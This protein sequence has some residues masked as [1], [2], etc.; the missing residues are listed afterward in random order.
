[1]VGRRR[2]VA[3]TARRVYYWRPKWWPG[4]QF[5]IM[6][7]QI[8]WTMRRGRAI[9][10]E[11]REFALYDAFLAAHE[12]YRPTPYPGRISLWRAQEEDPG[13]A[14]VS[15]DLG[16]Q[17]FAAGGLDITVIP[18]NHQSLVLEPN[19]DQLVAG[20]RAALDEAMNSKIS[21]AA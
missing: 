10:H 12:S 13:L 2:I 17:P 14:W 1:M 9:P 16:W 4:F 15:A 7:A 5:G 11:L 8:A 21:E 19:I 20:L 18:G 6:R 3:Q